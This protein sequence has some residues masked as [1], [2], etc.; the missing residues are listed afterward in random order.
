[1]S[2][3]TAELADIYEDLRVEKGLSQTQLAKELNINVK[4][5]SHYENGERTL[6][7]KTLIK[8]ADFF[9]VSTDYLLGRTSTKSPVVEI[10]AA[11]AKFG[12][13]ET[14]LI[15]FAQWNSER[16]FHLEPYSVFHT[17]NRF[18]GSDKLQGLIDALRLYCRDHLEYD[19]RHGDLDGDE[20]L[21]EYENALASARKLGMDIVFKG[22]LADAALFDASNILVEIAKEI[23]EAPYENE[24]LN[25]TNGGD[26]GKHNET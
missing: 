6:P 20:M 10:Q 2:K 24:E 3:S 1:V 21:A 13:A 7:A 26:N 19:Y 15:R 11:S 14:V 9:E 18:L 25:I 16:L 17:L 23:L 5:I 8:Y 22:T 4:T 12:L